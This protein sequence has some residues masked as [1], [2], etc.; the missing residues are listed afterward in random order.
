MKVTLLNKDRAKDLY[1][2][3]GE[4]A[5][6]CYD[7]ETNTPEKIGKHCKQSGHFSGS[8]SNY[9]IFRIDEVPRFVIDQAARAEIGV[10]KNIQSFRYVNKSSFA[11]EIPIEITDNEELLNKYHEHMMK[12]IALYEEIQEYVYEK[13]KIHERA[14]EQARY[15]LPMSTHSSYVIGFTIEALIHY[16]N[17]RLCTRTEDVHRKLAI[18]MKKAVLDILPGLKNDLVPNCQFLLWCPEGKRGCGMYPTKAEL[19]NM[20][21]IKNI[22]TTTE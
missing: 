2:E 18:E 14:N 1:K 13:T 11:Y 10:C 15:V 8:R 17:V 4:F 12:T 22:E 16:M 3:W 6:V 21:Q 9:I 7:T 20:L 5:R 19:M